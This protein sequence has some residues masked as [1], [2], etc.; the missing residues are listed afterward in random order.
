MK[1]VLITGAAGFIGFHLANHLQKRG[2]RV[3]GIDNFNDYYSVQLKRD[4]AQ[5]LKKLS[6]DIVEGDVCNKKALENIVEKN[7]IT[8]IV[9]L[10]AQAGVRYSL[11]NPEVYIHSNIDGFLSI[12]E[13]IKRHPEIKL[14][15]ASSSSVYGNNTKIPFSVMDT[16]DNQ[17]SLYGVTKK[18]NELM[19]ATYKHLYKLEAIG[20]R[21]FT[22]YGP[23]GRP[24]MAYYSFTKAILEGKEIEVFNFGKMERDFTYIDDIIEGTTAALDLV[25]KG[26]HPIYNL[27]NHKPE[28]LMTMIALLEKHLGKKAK[29]K[30]LPMQPGDVTTTY[31]DIALSEKDLG[32]HPKISLDEG[33]ANFTSWYKRIN[34]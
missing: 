7:K 21:Y 1:T 18:S 5:Q 8:H 30:Q 11:T 23:W 9:H 6:I 4:R 12:L 27:G 2:D 25:G 13:L 14:V 33:L 16:T 29:L 10:A 24:D 28:P 22:V 17:A 31:A 19:A 3:V 32:F 34:T 20:L 15:Y 26:K